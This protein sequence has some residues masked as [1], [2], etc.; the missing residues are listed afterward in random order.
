MNKHIGMYCYCCG[1]QPCDKDR[2]SAGAPR[3]FFWWKIEWGTKENVRFPKLGYIWYMVV[4]VV[5][6]LEHEFKTKEDK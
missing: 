6:A 5:A 4:W 3:S 2:S 1:N